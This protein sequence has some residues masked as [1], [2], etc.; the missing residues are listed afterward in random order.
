MLLLVWSDMTNM[1]FWIFKFRTEKLCLLTFLTRCEKCNNV[2]LCEMYVTCPTKFI[3]PVKMLSK[4]GLV[5][6]FVV[7]VI[8]VSVVVVVVIVFCFFF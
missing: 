4:N 7:A 6:L 8:V 5:L 2:F 3:L 1:T